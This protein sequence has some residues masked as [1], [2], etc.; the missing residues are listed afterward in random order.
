M[1][2]SAMKTVLLIIFLS[3]GNI[4]IAQPDNDTVAPPGLIGEPDGNGQ[5]PAVAQTRADLRTH[6][7]YR[8]LDLPDNPMPVLLWGNGGCSDNG[9]GHSYFLREVASHG[10]L[11][12]ALGYAKSER[13][14]ESERP[15]AAPPTPPANVGTPPT[16]PPDATHVEQH[17][18][19]MDWLTKRNSDPLDEL[20]GRADLSRIA[21]A[22]HSC[23]GLQAIKTA[24]DPR[25]DTAMIFNSGIYN[26]GSRGIS[27]LNVSK[28]ELDNLH[29]PIAYITGGPTD[30]AHLNSVDDVSRI[31]HVPVFFGWLPVGHGG[32]F[33]KA[34]DGAE[35]GQVAVHWLDW[36]FRE[37]E[38]AG[39]WFSGADCELCRAP[40]WTVE[41]FITR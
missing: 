37:D 23:G 29:G 12:I 1:K 21:V 5:W 20:Y 41:S 33:W 35:W 4:G 22:G 38:D 7:L 27:G 19:A 31:Q 39:R 9:L 24:A 13:P 6:T 32:T 40:G 36:Q 17:Y 34:A 28:N 15:A 8:P 25:I 14:L 2:T 10:Y 16:P 30:I 3:G 26:T 11:V 18:Y